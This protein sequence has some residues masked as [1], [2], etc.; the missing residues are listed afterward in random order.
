MKKIA[1]A[2]WAVA[3]LLPLSVS[4]G[5]VDVTAHVGPAFPTYRQSFSYDPG[6]PVAIPSS[7]VT[8]RQTGSFQLDAEGGIAFGAALAWQFA[9]PLGLE[10]RIDTTDVDVRTSG[11]R[12]RVEVDLPAP[13][14][15]LSTD[16]DLGTGVVDLERVRPISL[17]LRLRSPGR[18]G[19]TASAGVSY[20]PALRVT[21]TQRIGL[22]VTSLGVLLERLNVATLTLRAEA[23]PD[24]AHEGRWGGNLG[25]GA[26]VGI[27]KRLGLVAEA[28][29]F[30]F[31]KQ[32]LRWQ[33]ADD[34]PL[35]PLEQALLSEVEPRLAPLEFNP[36]FFQATIGLTVGF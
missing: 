2:A 29:G 30:L 9:G 6:I 18:F 4:A 31:Q 22:G 25:V 11:A 34:R 10:A 8:V 16:L 24:E 26:R 1:G 27:G 35:T 17:N 32:T 13:L 12:Y 7:I 28:R 21:A 15:D 33:P 23:Q 20:L 19:V 36:T 14:S 5:S 3:A